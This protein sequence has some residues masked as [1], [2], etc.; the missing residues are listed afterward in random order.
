MSKEPAIRAELYRV[1]KNSIQRGI[2][3]EDRK[4]SRIA[5]E[6]PV[7]GKKADL[8]VFHVSKSYNENQQP[9]I[10][11]ETKARFKHPA[12][13]LARATKQ[14]M[15]Y[16]EKL[17]SVFFAVYDGWNFL[18]FMRRSPYLIKLSN[19]LHVDESI[20]RNLLLGL[21]EFGYGWGIKRDETLER[22]PKIPDGWSFHQ[23][24]LPSIAKSLA[25]ITNP[26]L[27]D[28]WET[29]QEKWLPIIRRDGEW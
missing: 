4:I 3:C 27:E 7:Q 15:D 25:S 9:L 22:L 29:L 11:I 5:V 2:S 17:R 12:M 26:K 10:V 28:Y 19:F 24:I 13:P 1:L 21:L 16:A 20:G 8:V 14:A 6:Y 23:T 18:L